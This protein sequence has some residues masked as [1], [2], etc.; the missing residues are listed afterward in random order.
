MTANRQFINVQACHKSDVRLKRPGFLVP[1]S[2]KLRL[3]LSLVSRLL[4]RG[5][6]DLLFD[7]CQWLKRVVSGSVHGQAT[8][9]V[10]T[11]SGY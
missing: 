6:Q 3:I 8:G 5:R 9:F 11:V 10:D 2:H 1:Q 7:H 4:S